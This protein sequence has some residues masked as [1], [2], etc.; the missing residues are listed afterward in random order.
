MLIQKGKQKLIT[1]IFFKTLISLEGKIAYLILINNKYSIHTV[2]MDYF[3]FIFQ[4]YPSK[5]N[6]FS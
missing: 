2:K 6:L 5:A 4:I 1:V 3:T